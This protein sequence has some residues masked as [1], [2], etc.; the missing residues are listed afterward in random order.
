MNFLKNA[1]P[2]GAIADFRDVFHQAGR[3]RWWITLI[4]VSITVGL[5]ST[6]ALESWRKPPA[7]PTIVYITTLDPN[8]SDAEI[9]ASNLENQRRKDALAAQQEQREAEVRAI[10][11]KLGAMSGMDVAKAEREAAAERAAAAAQRKREQAEA[12]ERVRQS[13]LA[14]QR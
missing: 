2:A 1:N 3:N 14:G 12:L 8:R 6:L 5:F 9:R 10:Y 13:E 11:R 7:K 4:A